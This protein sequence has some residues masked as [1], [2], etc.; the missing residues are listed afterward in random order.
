MAA[1][2]VCSRLSAKPPAELVSFAERHVRNTRLNARFYPDRRS[3]MR[4]L[5]VVNVLVQP[6]DENSRPAGESFYAVTR[7][8]STEGVGLIAA[9]PIPHGLVALQIHFDHEDIAIIAEVKWSTPMGPF[10]AGGCRF[11]RKLPLDEQDAVFAARR[12]MH[13]R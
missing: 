13:R 11:L 12:M 9:E 3:E 8:I 10:E 6:L 1:T 2:A 7:D 5:L 4:H